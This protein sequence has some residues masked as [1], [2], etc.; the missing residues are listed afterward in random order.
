MTQISDIS[1][2]FANLKWDVQQDVNFKM[3]EPHGFHVLQL[4][5]FYSIWRSACFQ[6]KLFH[7]VSSCD[8]IQLT[9]SLLLCIKWICC[10]NS[11]EICFR[12]ICF[13]GGSRQTLKTFETNL[14]CFPLRTKGKGNFTLVLFRAKSF[15]IGLNHS[16]YVFG[17][18][19]TLYYIIVLAFTAFLGLICVEQVNAHY[20]YYLHILILPIYVHVSMFVSRTCQCIVHFVQCFHITVYHLQDIQVYISHSVVIVSH[21]IDTVCILC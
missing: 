5:W 1:M 6:F 8:I 2:Y 20:C 4:Y 15:Q 17:N 10:E 14:L 9:L 3:A 18:S 11:W 12:Q 7:H 21:H 13:C 19:S 16:C